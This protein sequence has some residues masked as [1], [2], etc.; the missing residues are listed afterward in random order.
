MKPTLCRLRANFGPGLPS[1]TNSRMTRRAP[2]SARDQGPRASFERLL[3]LVAAGGGLGSRGLG[4]RCRS[5]STRGRSGTSRRSSSTRSRSSS[6][7]FQLFG[8][9]GRRHDGDEGRVLGGQRLYAGRQLDVGEMQGVADFERTDVSLDELR[10][11]LHAA[12]ELDRMRNDVHGAAALHA[13]RTFS[14]HHVQ[15]NADA[16]G[17]AFAEPHEVDMDREVL[18]RIEVVVARNH[19]VLVAFEVDVDQR[20]QEPAG[21]DAR[22][23]FAIVNRDG[24]RGLVVAIDHSGYSPGAT[25]SPGGPLAALRTCGRLQFLD[26]RH[27]VKSLFSKKLKAASRPAGVLQQASRGAGAADVAGF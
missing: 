13:G 25:L 10:D 19:A 3:L 11:V 27:N 20:G 23:Q 2:R 24:Q 7:G 9:A 16:D 15:G 22:A 26:G 17:G 12:L 21:K 8:V 18:D 4:S 14:L 5:S 6:R 1:P